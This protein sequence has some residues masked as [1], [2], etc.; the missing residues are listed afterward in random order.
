MS[1]TFRLH[2]LNLFLT[3]PQCSLNPN[4]AVATIKQKLKNYEWAVFGSELHAD[5]SP[6]LHAFVRLS[7]PCNLT[8][9]NCLDLTLSDG[10]TR[11][12]D[13]RVA[14]DPKAVLDYC[15]KDGK[16]E[17]FNIEL[18]AA[19]ALF[20]AAGKKRN[21]T[22]VILEAMKDGKSLEQAARMYPEHMTFA[23]L[24]ADRLKKFFFQEMIQSLAPP[25]RFGRAKTYYS[26]STMQD[27]Q[28][29]RW[30]NK[31]MLECSRPLG[32]KQLWIA[33]PTCS[34]KTTLVETLKQYFRVYTVPMDEDFYD[35]YSDSSYDLIVFDEFRHQKTVQWM[36][37]FVDGQTCPLRQKGAQ[38]VKRKNLPVIVLSN[39]RMRESYPN[40]EQATFDTIA[41]RF[42]EVWLEKPMTIELNP[43]EDAGTSDTM[44]SIDSVTNIESSPLLE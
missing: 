5:G 10:T 36:N 33:G 27:S 39:Y 28:I 4:D 37:R 20:T 15:T 25:K 13:Y 17:C 18:D 40:V 34:G 9:P 12:G 19:R 26:K 6:H 11:H 7:K 35:E 30:L 14:R 2:G 24:H 16:V 43:A 38:I 22:E 41:R 8:S 21:A 3:Y 23:M 29:A 31:N 44:E 1:T 42:E 32:T